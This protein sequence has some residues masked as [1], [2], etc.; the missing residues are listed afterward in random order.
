M[1]T[2]NVMSFFSTANAAIITIITLSVAV[3]SLA[4][5]VRDQKIKLAFYKINSMLKNPTLPLDYIF[6][7]TRKIP[8]KRITVAN[9]ADED[10]EISGSLLD[11]CINNT[12]SDAN[13]LK[14]IFWNI[15]LN[16]NV[17]DKKKKIMREIVAD[18]IRRIS[19]AKLAHIYVDCSFGE[20][21]GISD[22][23]K[24]KELITNII[25]ANNF[26][27]DN[28]LKFLKSV[29][30][31]FEYIIRNPELTEDQK[32]IIQANEAKFR[33]TNRDLLEELIPEINAK[34]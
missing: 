27:Y 31:R 2:L 20:K 26:T 32:I 4:L 1:E 30:N 17:K 24:E 11:A 29:I 28:R 34:K 23:K 15:D 33:I 12:I 18:S 25:N 16:L 3:T 9:I 5:I 8:A 21:D 6:V 7:P 14:T 19:A 22:F 10:R 13:S